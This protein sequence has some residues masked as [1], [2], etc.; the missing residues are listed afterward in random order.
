[1]RNRILLT[2]ALLIPLT[3]GATVFRTFMAGLEPVHVQ[4]GASD[5]SLTLTRPVSG[6]PAPPTL[7]PNSST[8]LPTAAL[9]TAS[10][11]SPTGSV[12]TP[13]A[14]VPSLTG[15]VPSPTPTVVAEAIPATA[16][17]FSEVRA[18]A[19]PAF[20]SKAPAPAR[21]DAGRAPGKGKAKGKHRD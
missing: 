19:Q 3:L 14:S 7:A 9:P 16:V 12:P 15:P 17:A 2:V 13:T 20:T 11:P 5:V 4:S 8:A 21:A 18:A 6:A 1:M 10:V